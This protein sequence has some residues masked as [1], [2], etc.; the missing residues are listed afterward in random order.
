M[1]LPQSRMTITIPVT[2]TV[3]LKLTSTAK[4]II[5]IVT[6][7]YLPPSRSYSASG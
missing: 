3:T 1:W 7:Q 5:T 6:A 2:S 4:L